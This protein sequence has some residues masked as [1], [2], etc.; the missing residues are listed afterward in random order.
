MLRDKEETDRRKKTVGE[1]KG[2][3]FVAVLAQIQQCGHVTNE[4]TLTMPH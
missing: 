1:E 3:G 2:K 4:F